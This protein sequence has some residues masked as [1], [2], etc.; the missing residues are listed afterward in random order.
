MKSE[1][2]VKQ[3]K[4]YCVVEISLVRIGCFEWIK[5]FETFVLEIRTTLHLDFRKGK[6]SWLQMLYDLS[7][8]D[9]SG[10]Y[11][12]RWRYYDFVLF[13]S[14]SDDMKLLMDCIT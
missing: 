8:G 14:S 3:N 11:W 4:I 10:K 2:F 6:F 13:K 5:P 9:W 7:L 1:I 12:N